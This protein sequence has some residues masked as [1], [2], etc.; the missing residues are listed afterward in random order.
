MPRLLTLR[1]AALNAAVHSV[2][3]SAFAPLASFEA[4]TDGLS[5]HLRL[6]VVDESCKAT[7]LS[8]AFDS[9]TTRDSF[10]TNF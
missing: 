8:L 4:T 7:Y 2:L 10:L 1:K 5:V 9:A 3:P 6:R